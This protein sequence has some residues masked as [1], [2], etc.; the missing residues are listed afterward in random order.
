MPPSLLPFPDLHHNAVTG[1][2]KPAFVPSLK[3]TL[4][5]C[6]CEERND[7][8]ISY[9]RIQ[10]SPRAARD[11]KHLKLLSYTPLL[12]VRYIAHYVE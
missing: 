4:I 6:H 2:T 9:P 1:E 8:A 7:E 11:D 12:P 3:E 10:R 5:N